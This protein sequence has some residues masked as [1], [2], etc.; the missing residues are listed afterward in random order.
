MFIPALRLARD[1]ERGG[2]DFLRLL[3]RAYADPAPFEHPWTTSQLYDT[4]HDTFLPALFMREKEL[5]EDIQAE[6]DD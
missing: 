3:G 1:P 2:K 5:W 6:E 4:I